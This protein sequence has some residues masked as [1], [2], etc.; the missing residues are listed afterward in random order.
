MSQFGYQI[1]GLI[2]MFSGL[3]TLAG[4]KI[5]L[6]PEGWQYIEKDF[7]F[8]L[9][10]VEC[11]FIYKAYKVNQNINYSKCPKCVLLVI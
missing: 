11:I 7:S 6:R 2:F 4:G 10:G 5:L 8:F 1:L 9:F 3:W